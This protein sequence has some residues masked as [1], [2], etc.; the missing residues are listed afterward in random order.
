MKILELYRQGTKEATGGSIRPELLREI[1]QA[2]ETLDIDFLLQ[3]IPSALDQS[4]EGI[5][6]VSKIVRAMKDFSHPH[7][8]EKTAIDINHAIESTITV[9][10]NEWKYVAQIETELDRTLPAVKC[11]PGEINQVILNLIVN[12]AHAIN[13]V[14]GG[15]EEKGTIRVTTARACEWV[16]IRI[17]DSGTG[18]PKEVQPR[19]FEPFFTTKEVGKGTGQGLPIARSVVVDKHGGT[20]SFESEIGKGTTF[21][22]RLPLD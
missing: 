11:L 10:R 8:A 19:L 9:A 4:L 5:E 6:R 20:I 21:I 3:E 17:S 12:A 15:T 2:R 16:E 7:S 14:V 18:I 22:V 13:D 1:E